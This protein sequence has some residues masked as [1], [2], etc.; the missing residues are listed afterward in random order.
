MENMAVSWILSH[1]VEYWE[2]LL[3]QEVPAK[4]VGGIGMPV[5][6]DA[7][8]GQE[9]ITRKCLNPVL[10]YNDILPLNPWEQRKIIYISWIVC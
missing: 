3:K 7:V 2:M 8:F 5:Q 6:S 4:G 10:V 1:Q 9:H